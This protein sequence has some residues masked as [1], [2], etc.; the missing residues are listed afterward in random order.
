MNPT[1]PIDAVVHANPYPYYAELA[2][3][4]LFV[5]EP[6]RGLWL[7]PIAA[8]AIGVLLRRGALAGRDDLGWTCRPPANL[9][10]PVFAHRAGSADGRGSQDAR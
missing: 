7:A 8:A 1:D 4:A 10:L 6:R 3:R 9:R 2:A 5:F